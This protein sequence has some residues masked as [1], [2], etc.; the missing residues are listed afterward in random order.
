M[1]G[2]GILSDMNKVDF[3]KLIG[4][5]DGWTSLDLYPDDFFL[6]QYREYLSLL[7]SDEK[8][9]PENY[10]NGLYWYWFRRIHQYDSETIATIRGLLQLEPEV[11][12]RSSLLRELRAIEEKIIR[13]PSAS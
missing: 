10:R 9:G 3:A 5:P 13:F 8:V 6:P 12:M 11:R 7:N 2:I 4:L 1:S